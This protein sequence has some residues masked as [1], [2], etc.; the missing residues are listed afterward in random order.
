[1]SKQPKRP[2]PKPQRPTPKPR[3][4]RE[5]GQQKGLPRIPN[6]KK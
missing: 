5:G 2:Q 4:I 3:P 1:M 6:P